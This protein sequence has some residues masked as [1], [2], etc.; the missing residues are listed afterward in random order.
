[1]RPLE[2][3]SPVPLWAQLADDLRQRVADGEFDQLL[4]SELELV[5]EYEVSRNTVREALRR[6]RDEHLIERQRGRGTS[7]VDVEI[8]R[9][10]PGT[11][12]L[13]RNIEDQ[14]LAERSEV[15]TIDTRPAAGAHAALE[16]AS[17]ADVVYIER[18]RFAGDE[19]LALDRS[20]LPAEI[21]RPL[22]RADLTHGSLY[23]TL[24]ARCDVR[25]VRGN[26]RITPVVPSVR[27]RA[28]LRLPRQAAAFKVERLAYSTDGPVES[29]SSIVRGDRYRLISTWP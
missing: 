14:G 15:V 19:P 6:L 16:L 4:P 21:A 26:E 27:D 20:W 12:S 23:D 9:T 5:A 13:A 2:R 22:L 18:V 10:M 7:L 11:Y 8:E 25:V 28:K 1:V 24:L 17:G 29:R 3:T